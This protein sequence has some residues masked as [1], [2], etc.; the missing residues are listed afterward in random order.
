MKNLLTLTCI[1]LLTFGISNTANAQ[2]KN[3]DENHGN[4]LNTFVSFGDNT[5]IAA[6]YEF[7][8]VRNVTISPE[9]KIWFAGES[10]IALGA[11]ADY[12]FDS[13]LNL[14]KDWDIWSGID[15]SF[16]LDGNTDFQLNIHAG[17]EYIING[18]WGIIAEFGSGK[19]TSGGIGL[20][21]HF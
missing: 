6:N 12:Y 15:A 19:V 17:V 20:A 8:V 3:S 1:V 7:Q 13:L 11:R 5:A 21:I 16:F 18:S 9:A 2:D 4:T 14:H 10:T